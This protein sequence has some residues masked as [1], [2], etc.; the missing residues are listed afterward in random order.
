MSPL[1][2][3]LY[4]LIVCLSLLAIPVS[5]AQTTPE[6]WIEK[7]QQ[8][9][10]EAQTALE[11]TR[12]L[13][14]TRE[15]ALRDLETT[16]ITPQTFEEAAQLRQAT[17]M[18]LEQLRSERKNVQNHLDTVAQ[19]QPLVELDQQYLELL[20]AQMELLIKQTVLA[21]EWHTQLQ[22]VS[23]LR[24][25]KERELGI[26]DAQAALKRSQEGL[27]KVQEKLPNYI[28][29][30][31][32]ITFDKLTEFFEQATLEKIRSMLTLTI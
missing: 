30:L 12:V 16:E 2:P 6:Q 3:I 27:Q 32:A 24:Q 26:A 23:Q 21:I 19:N 22:T 4:C 11:Q 25:L 18:K 5:Q 20:K 7:R 28:A 29:M 15:Q 1:K 13:L 10:T 8:Q 14:Q 31:D 9:I 17:N